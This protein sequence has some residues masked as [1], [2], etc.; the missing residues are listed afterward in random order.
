MMRAWSQ[1]KGDNVQRKNILRILFSFSRE[2][3][4]LIGNGRQRSTLAVTTLRPEDD[5][6]DDS[7]LKANLIKS[8]MS[9]SGSRSLLERSSGVNWRSDVWSSDANRPARIGDPPG[10]CESFLQTSRSSERVDW[11]V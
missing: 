9:S 6:L 8:L 2:P 4:I 3:S 11:K 1:Q 7:F 5:K 10:C